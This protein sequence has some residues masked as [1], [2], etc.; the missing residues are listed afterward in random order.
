MRIN[1]KVG[2]LIFFCFIFVLSLM[3]LY[4]NGTY[5]SYE[6]KISGNVDF[7]IAKWDIRINDI[8]VTG[9]ESVNINI[10]NIDWYTEHVV[11]GKA[12]PGSRGVANIVINPGETGVAFSYMIDLIDKNVD[13]N[14]ILTV[15]SISSTDSSFTKISEGKYIGSFSID[16]INSGIS[17]TISLDVEWVNDDSINDFDIINQGNNFLGINFSASQKA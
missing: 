8:V 10:S 7:N 17:K 4:S 12:A 6:S 1:K 16:E 11:E 13:T 2:N 9:E 3:Y 14:Y 5:T 15:N